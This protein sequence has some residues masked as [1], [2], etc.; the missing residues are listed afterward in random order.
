MCSK[1]RAILDSRD[2]LCKSVSN[3]FEVILDRVMIVDGGVSRRS[4]SVGEA[5]T[6]W[7][8]AAYEYDSEVLDGTKGVLY[9][10][11]EPMEWSFERNRG[12]REYASDA[13]QRVS[14]RITGVED[15][16]Y[17]LT[18]INNAVALPSVEWKRHWVA[19]FIY[20]LILIALI[21]GGSLFWWLRRRS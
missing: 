17:G 7:F 3:D 1:A 6:V 15:E 18:T 10:N 20:K 19:G 16:K 11:G 21:I 13:P 14:F 4:T 2:R 8:K 9:V 5:E 12:E